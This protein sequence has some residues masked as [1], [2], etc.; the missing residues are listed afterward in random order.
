MEKEEEEAMEK[1]EKEQNIK[2]QKGKGKE[3]EE[4]EPCR[5]QGIHMLCVSPDGPANP[6]LYFLSPQEEEEEPHEEGGPPRFD[7][8]AAGKPRLLDLGD[9]VYAPNTLVLGSSGRTLLW[10][11]IQERRP[12]EALGYAGCLTVPRELSLSRDGCRLIQRPAAEVSELRLSTDPVLHLRGVEVNTP[13]GAPGL[14]LDRVSG[15]ALDLELQLR[16]KE[17]NGCRASGLLLRS[18]DPRGPCVTVLFDWNERRLEVQ[19]GALEGDFGRQEAEERVRGGELSHVPWEP[20]GL[21]VLIDHSVL[22]VFA[23]NGETLTTRVYRGALPEGGA[24]RCCCC[25]SQCPDAWNLGLLSLDGASEA[26]VDAWEMSS[27]WI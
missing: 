11:W 23:S 26:D 18:S 21:R 27:I 2:K 12:T 19:G 9:T 10:G 22:E 24:W 25:P 7:L 14:P 8:A 13:S 6:V 5:Q 3:E 16:L 15:S 1:G 20:L 17:G 4:E